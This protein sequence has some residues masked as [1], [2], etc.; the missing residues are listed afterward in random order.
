MIVSGNFGQAQPPTKLT[1]ELPL[2]DSK[3]SNEQQAAN[4]QKVNRVPFSKRAM[5]SLRRRLRPLRRQA[6][7]AGIVRKKPKNV[8]RPLTEAE[9]SKKRLSKPPTDQQAWVSLMLRDFERHVSRDGAD[10]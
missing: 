8:K 6:E 5:R 3:P 10:R 2:A 7:R 1:E 4:T 9:K